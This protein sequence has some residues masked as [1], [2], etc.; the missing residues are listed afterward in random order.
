MS[1]LTILY[2]EDERPLF[3][4]VENLMAKRGYPA[5]LLWADSLARG[6]EILSDYDV[7]LVLLDLYLPDSQGLETVKK[8]RSAAPQTPIVVLTGQGDDDLADMILESGAQEYLEK[9]ELRPRVLFR[10]IRYASERKKMEDRL[11]Q[12]KTGLEEKVEE[13]TRELYNA[14]RNLNEEVTERR[15]AEEAL[16]ESEAHYRLLAEN[17]TDV[18]W[19]ADLGLRFKYLSPS[20]KLLLGYQVQELMAM[21]RRDVFAPDSLELTSRAIETALVQE[22]AGQG[23]SA[24]ALNL[25]LELKR[26]DGSTVWTDTRFSFLREQAG[27]PRG[28][29]AVTRDITEA[30]AIRIAMQRNYDRQNAINYLLN[31]TLEEMTLED[32]L[33]KTLNILLGIPWLTSESQGAIF[34]VESDPD[35]LVMK[36]HSV[37]S[38]SKCRLCSRI[39]VGKCV[40]GQAATGAKTIFVDRVDHQHE[41]SYPGME[42]HGHYCVPM[43]MGG[44]TMGVINLCLREGYVPQEGEEE[45]LTAYANALAMAIAHL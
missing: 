30:R 25:E 44:Q 32:L 17:I 12:A 4:L 26:R 1:D 16:R 40:C 37:L 45:F 15:L 9:D 19:T 34:L 35:Y 23:D 13:R 2:I 27:V 22:R 39:P 28:L 41:F 3:T 14:I 36:V 10:A 29:L 6:L 42:G 33:A 8:I 18:I 7:G 5:R 21:R 24:S 38:D 11:R 43:L 20:V 31:L